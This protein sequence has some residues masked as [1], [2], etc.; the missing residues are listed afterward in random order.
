MKP[1]LSHLQEVLPFWLDA[2]FVATTI[3]TVSLFY[4]TIRQVSQ[5][6]VRRFLFISLLWL[7]G[8]AVVAANQFFLH[9][10]AKPPRFVFV[11]GP[12]LFLIIVLVATTKGRFWI[13][14]LPLS[15][16]TLLHIVRLPV[17]LTLYGL[18]VYQQIPQLMTFEGRNYDILAGLTA[19]LVAYF[20]FK[21]GKLSVR[22]LFVWNI[23]ALG[24]VVNIVI[25]AILSAPFPF[26][27]V[28]FEQPNVAVLK[29]P[30]VWLPGVIV[31]IVLFSHV[32][33]IQRLSQQLRDPQPLSYPNS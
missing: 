8:L 17:E 6:G 22:W 29:A 25:Y 14:Q 13:S 3:L 10:N 7:A 26:Q 20:A 9:L 1:N 23:L 32:I 30:Y 15:R 19:P 18:Y 16:L 5:I 2:F 12:P 24:L 21:S 27:Q 11:I 4:Y 28:G 31:P 33:V